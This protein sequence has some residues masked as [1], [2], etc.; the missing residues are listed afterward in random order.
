MP[1]KRPRPHPKSY[2]TR[3]RASSK[4]GKAWRR[5]RRRKK[6]SGRQRYNRTMNRTN[7]KIG[8]YVRKMTLT[9]R[10]KALEAGSRKH[11]DYASLTGE[12]ITWNGT[13]LNPAK[14]SYSGLLAVQG[15]LNTGGAGDPAL[16]ENEQ[17]MNDTIFCKSVRI[18][19]EI[20]GIRPQD[21]APP[22]D[23][24]FVLGPFGQSYMESV[25][26]TKIYITLLQ[27]LRPSV[28]DSGGNSDIN[29]LP[30]PVSAGGEGTALA[31]MYELPPAGSSLQ[32]FGV[33]NALR[34]YDSSRFKIIHCE[35]VQT[36]LK[37]PSKMFDITVKINRTLKYV[38]PRPPPSTTNPEKV[39]YNYN[40]LVFFSM[41][42]HP[43]PLGW[44]GYLSPASVTTKSSRMYF[45]DA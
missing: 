35:C 6:T 2:Y 43:V 30:L 12:L 8:R 26:S 27:D 39:P 13:D 14:N 9:K 33:T 15:P 21:L 1:Y 4:I 42:S 23:P 20:R 10:V 28:V 31:S 3:W 25:C 19:G 24:S 22:N 18:K 37:N 5:H 41:V 34:S 29:P 7:T 32:F 36:S 40:L 38:P 44:S 11:H 45:V 17:R 16:Q